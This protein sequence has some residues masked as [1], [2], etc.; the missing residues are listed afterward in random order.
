M[1][2]VPMFLKNSVFV[3]ILNPES[4]TIIGEKNN[5]NKEGSNTAL[6][7]LCIRDLQINYKR[8]INFGKTH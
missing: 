6:Y 2:I 5:V 4:N 7:L 8:N 3:F 1:N